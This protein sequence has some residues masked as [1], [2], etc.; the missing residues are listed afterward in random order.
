MTD[1][2]ASRDA[3][4][5]HVWKLRCHSSP[6]P[7][8]RLFFFFFA[9]F[10][11]LM[12]LEV[13]ETRAFLGAKTLKLKNFPKSWV[14]WEIHDFHLKKGCLNLVWPKGEQ[15]AGD[16]LIPNSRCRFPCLLYRSMGVELDRVYC[17]FF[18]EDL[19]CRL[20]RTCFSV[21]G[22]SKN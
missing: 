16:F 10:F 22:Q 14:Q 18:A 20:R 7:A 12:S 19:C 21:P 3:K 1:P 5:K 13:K 17:R 2:K 8:R 4:M 9:T 11:F 15:Q 6:E